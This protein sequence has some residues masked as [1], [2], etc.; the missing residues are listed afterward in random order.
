V[1][2]S[3]RE[4][5]EEQNN[6]KKTKWLYDLALECWGGFLKKT[7]I[8]KKEKNLFM[9]FNTLQIMTTF[10]MFHTNLNY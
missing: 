9:N 5:T 4:G 2:Q 10:S 7:A 3:I 1:R 8:E 6:V